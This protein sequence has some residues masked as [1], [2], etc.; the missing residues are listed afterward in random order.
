MTPSSPRSDQNGTDTLAVESGTMPTTITAAVADRLRGEIRSGKLGPGSHLR[1]AHV[2][3]EYG[4]STTPVREAFA[5]LEREGLLQS[6]A[7]RG[8]IVFEPS[9]EE[10]REIYEIRVPL[11]AL[12]TELGVANLS[13]DDLKRLSSSIKRWSA[14]NRKRDWVL[15]AELND[16]FH[17]AIYAAA[18][19]PRLYQ[20]ISELRASSQAYIGLFPRATSRVKEVEREHKAIYEACL[21]RKPKKAAKAMAEHLE[22]M[23]KSISEGIEGAER[24]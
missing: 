7:H 1:Q 23:A 16:D 6:N 12:A 14:A 17:T 9:A 5:A 18:Q 8:V 2:A 11:E 10:L 22:Y 24:G 21:A 4:V 19:R 15:S 3:A 20:L 13:D